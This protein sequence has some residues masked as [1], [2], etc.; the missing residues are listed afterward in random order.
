MNAI[1]GVV[2]KSSSSKIASVDENGLVTCHKTGTVTITATAKD[3][4]GKKATFKL[5]VIKTVVSLEIGDQ[6][7]KSGK[8]RNLSRLV[9]I[10]PTD[11]TNKKLNYQIVTGKEYATV[12]A[13]GSLKAKK[14]TQP[15]IVEVLITS[16]ESGV[17]RLIQVT[18]TP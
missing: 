4:S 11:A 15:Q 6:S 18:F 10:L 8:T 16:Q 12:S 7:V 5:K 13:S 3:G 1:Q 2:W 9:T 14:V 17:S